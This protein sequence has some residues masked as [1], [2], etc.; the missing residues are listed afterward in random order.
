MV[1][2]SALDRGTRVTSRTA[3]PHLW[4]EP[5]SS[6]ADFTYVGLRRA[7]TAQPCQPCVGHCPQLH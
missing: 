7:T 6:V 4:T 3:Q 5:Q 2:L 1:I